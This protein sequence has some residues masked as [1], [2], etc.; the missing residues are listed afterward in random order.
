MTVQKKIL[1]L[2]ASG[3]L[4]NA[5][6]RFLASNRNHLVCGSVRSTRAL[7]LF[8]PD[9]R[10]QVVVGSDALEFDSLTRLF[11]LARPDVVVNCIGVV[12][13]LAE[14][15]DP[16][17]AIPINSILPHRLAYLAA[18]ADARPV[19]MSTDCVFSGKKGMYREADFAD[20]RV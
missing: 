17:I 2:G 13:Q 7:S 10:G 14:A 11:A 15:E 12:K 16:L 20:C 3:M 1:V 6:F 8:V 4:G 9:R 18:A 19:H 5:V